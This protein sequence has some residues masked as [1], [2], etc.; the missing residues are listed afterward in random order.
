MF[1]MWVGRAGTE[2]A[3]LARALERA[4]DRGVQDIPRI[5]AREADRLGISVPVATQYLSRNLHFRFGSAERHGLELFY[6]LAARL[7]GRAASGREADDGHRYAAQSFSYTVHSPS[8]S[9]S[10]TDASVSSPASNA[11]SASSPS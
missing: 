6:R 9:S 3:A 11:A 7:G 1:A 5:A 4:R 10:S 8:D 2:T